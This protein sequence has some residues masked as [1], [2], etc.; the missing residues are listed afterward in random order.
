MACKTISTLVNRAGINNLTGLETDVLGTRSGTQTPGGKRPKKA[1]SAKK[2]VQGEDVK[3]L[4]VLSNGVLK[5][6]LR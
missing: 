5:N 2:N 1:S 3:K 4:D 6:A